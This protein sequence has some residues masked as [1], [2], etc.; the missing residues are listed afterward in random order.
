MNRNMKYT[1]ETEDTLKKALRKG[2]SIKQIAE[3]LGVTR[4]TIYSWLKK[5]TI[6]TEVERYKTYV[7]NLFN[8]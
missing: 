7:D 1:K 4:A 2:M 5:K 6:R 3:K 8:S